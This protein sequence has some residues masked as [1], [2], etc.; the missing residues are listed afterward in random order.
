MTTF[1][2]RRPGAPRGFFA[3][4]AAGL[5]WL[6]VPGGVP[7]AE[8]LDVTDQSITLSSVTTAPPSAAAARAFGQQL[9]R[10]HDAGAAAFGIGPDG[11]A[12]DGFI[13]NAPL[14]LRPHRTWGEFYAA[15][16]LLPYA[17]T[18]AGDGA[19]SARGLALIE[20]LAERLAN[21]E[22]DDPAPPA[23]IHGDLW[24]GNVLFA[25][26]SATLIDPA[27]HGGHR[28]TDLAMLALF[29][30]PHLSQVYEA[31]AEA[32]THLP[33]NWPDLIGLHQLHPLLVHAVLF[34]ASYGEQAIEVARRC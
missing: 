26:D 33:P 11:W 10:T 2:K 18:A 20:A 22:F 9:A 17:R 32:S 1:T 19:L 8:L 25:G 21:G 3:V 7:V 29:G 28:I 16:R 24:A 4:E 27:A 31:Y 5:S 12:G 34:G 13:G 15:E 23:R 30:L 14:P 6:N